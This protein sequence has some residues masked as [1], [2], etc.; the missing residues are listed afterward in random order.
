MTAQPCRRCHTTPA[1]IRPY[2]AT[3]AEL[4]GPC[5][6][7]VAEWLDSHDRWPPVPWDDDETAR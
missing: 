3:E 4:C 5:A 2:W 6:S 7:A 1:T